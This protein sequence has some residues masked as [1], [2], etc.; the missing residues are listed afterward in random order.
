MSKKQSEGGSCIECS[1]YC[2]AT[3]AQLQLKAEKEV[4]DREEI[5]L[6]EA[7]VR[8]ANRRLYAA[9]NKAV[10]ARASLKRVKES[11]KAE[12]QVR[13]NE[14]E[15]EIAEAKEDLATAHHELSSSRSAKY[16]GG[17]PDVA[18]TCTCKRLYN[19]YQKPG[20]LDLS[21]PRRNVWGTGNSINR[22][23]TRTSHYSGRLVWDDNYEKMQKDG[24]ICKICWK[25]TSR[26]TSGKQ[27]RMVFAE[28]YG[29]WMRETWLGEAKAIKDK[30][31]ELA[32]MTLEGIEEK[33]MLSMIQEEESAD[34]NADEPVSETS[35]QRTPR[36]RIAKIR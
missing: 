22:V 20:I 2:D 35:A 29:Y 32:K 25:G 28:E 1:L 34:E 24:K 7:H 33:Q 17:D 6:I 15:A 3:E 30:T 31:E 4:R 5:K 19:G 21:L 10:K 11:L 23:C 8:T 36:R 13:V 27:R 26:G 18:R 9:R 16:S 12:R 14:A